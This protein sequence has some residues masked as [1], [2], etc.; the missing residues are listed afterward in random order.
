MSLKRFARQQ[1][2]RNRFKNSFILKTNTCIVC[3]VH[4]QPPPPP[5]YQTLT[6]ADYFQGSPTQAV[7]T[8]AGCGMHRCCRVTRKVWLHR[9][10]PHRWVGLQSV[11]S[12]RLPKCMIGIAI[13]VLCNCIS[14]QDASIMHK[15][16][17]QFTQTHLQTFVH[18][19]TR[20]HTQINL[21]TFIHLNKLTFEKGSWFRLFTTWHCWYSRYCRYCYCCICYCLQFIQWGITCLMSLHLKIFK[22]I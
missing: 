9:T 15:L 10:K 11:Y 1:Q 2:N 5:P 12:W 17:E 4:Y 7:P 16:P 8:L 21:H 14:V 22:E 18:T 3:I 13:S 19:H 6:V 20:T